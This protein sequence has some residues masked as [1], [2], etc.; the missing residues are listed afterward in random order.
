MA[1]PL[2]GVRIVEIAGIGPGPVRAMMLSDMGAEVVRIDRA[3][4][5]RRA[6]RRLEVR[7]AQPR[8]PLALALD[9]KNPDG[10][11]TLLA[12]SS[13]PTRCSRASGPA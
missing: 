10:V 5:C 6:G 7:R 12:W 9:L 3:Q 1:G 13:R 11:E 2:Q 4:A 8:A